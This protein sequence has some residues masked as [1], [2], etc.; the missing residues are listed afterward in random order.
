MNFEYGLT[1]LHRGGGEP[2]NFF[3]NAS[4]SLKGSRAQFA[5]PISTYIIIG[6]VLFIIALT[7]PLAIPAVRRRAESRPPKNLIFRLSV[8]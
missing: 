5:E 3:L 7:I 8:V 6:G 2:A 4:R 1:S